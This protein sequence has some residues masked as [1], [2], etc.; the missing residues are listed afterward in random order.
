MITAASLV[1]ALRWARSLGFGATLG[2]CAGLIARRYL[3]SIPLADDEA[4][5]CG[6]AIGALLHRLIDGVAV[7]VLRP[8]TT[9]SSFYFKLAQLSLLGGTLTAE[10]RRDIKRKLAERHFLGD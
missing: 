7:W 5:Y 1:A 10:Q 6:A 2:G 9:F 3:P 8:L 4:M